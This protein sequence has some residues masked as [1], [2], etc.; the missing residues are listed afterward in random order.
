MKATEQYF[1]VVLFIMLYKVV[2]TFESGGETHL[3]IWLLK[4]KL[5]P[6]KL[7]TVHTQYFNFFLKLT[8]YTFSVSVSIWALAGVQ[9]LKYFKSRVLH[10][11]PDHFHCRL[12][13][14]EQSILHTTGQDWLHIPATVSLQHMIPAN[15]RAYL[16]ALL[17]C[18]WTIHTIWNTQLLLICLSTFL[19]DCEAWQKIK[20]NHTQTQRKW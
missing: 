9:T 17:Q 15:I 20:T 6:A 16:T 7:A 12:P 5:N 10:F 18:K 3:S 13:G 14:R 8:K 19:E 4:W 2:L 11:S 1:P